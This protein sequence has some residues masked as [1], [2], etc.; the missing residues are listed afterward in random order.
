MFLEIDSN[1]SVSCG[2]GK[3][4]KNSLLMQHLRWLLLLPRHSK[5][6]WGV[7]SLILHLHMLSIL[8]KNIKKFLLSSYKIISS[9]VTIIGLVL[10]ISECFGKTLIPFNFDE[11]LTQVVAQVTM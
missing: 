9:L 8:I 7:C 1:T 6:S 3:I 4:F 5:V 10:S 11:K 2:Y